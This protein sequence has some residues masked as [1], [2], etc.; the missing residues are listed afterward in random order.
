MPNYPTNEQQR[1]SDPFEQGDLAEA[2]PHSPYQRGPLA[3]GQP[4][5]TPYASPVSHFDQTTWESPYSRMPQESNLS[6]DPNTLNRPLPS[7]SHS[8]YGL[9]PYALQDPGVHPVAPEQVQ[10]E[11]ASPLLN[12][13]SYANT[14]FPGSYSGRTDGGYAQIEQSDEQGNMVRYG[15]IPSRQPRRFKTVKRVELSHGNLV[16][17]CPVP[18][19]LLQMCSLRNE[20]EFT[21][22]RCEKLSVPP[23]GMQRLKQRSQR[24]GRDVRS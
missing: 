2:Q 5:E 14:S 9:T 20:R 8:S 18:D 10:P 1:R 3:M 21:H 19:K 17:D 11:D 7:T 23:L 15:K 12:N 4:Q 6:S 22:M 24:Y 16:L 13:A